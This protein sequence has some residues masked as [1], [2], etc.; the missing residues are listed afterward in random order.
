MDTVDVETKPAEPVAKT[1]EG[2]ALGLG[3]TV[4]PELR[5]ETRVD[6]LLGARTDV[7][8]REPIIEE[9]TPIRS[10]P[11]QKQHRQAVGVWSC[12]TTTSST[13][14]LLLGAWSHGVELSNGSRYVSTLSSLVLRSTEYPWTVLSCAGCC[15]KVPPK[16]RSSSGVW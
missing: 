16:V 1:A 9:A 14:L 7:V 6:P 13:R 5:T 2:T 4:A 15:R 8:V 3:T 10:A 12:W 11:C